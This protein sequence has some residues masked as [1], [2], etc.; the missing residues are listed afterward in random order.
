MA[1]ST[2]E[3]LIGIYEYHEASHV[4]PSRYVTI[5]EARAM[6]RDQTAYFINRGQDIRMA[7]KVLD[8]DARVGRAAM[9]DWVVVHSSALPR[10]NSQRRLP[11][12]RLRITTRQLNPFFGQAFGESA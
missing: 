9:E 11:P 1:T 10:A 12:K 7:E 2:P 8:Y 5:T 4:P 6:K 3:K